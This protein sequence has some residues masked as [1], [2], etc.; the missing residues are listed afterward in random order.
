M[1]KEVLIELAGLKL[2]ARLNQSEVAE[3][4]W[5]ALPL[6]AQ[7]RLWGDELYF[8]VPLSLAAR[9]PQE[10]VEKGDLAYWAAGPALCI[11][12]GPTPASKGDECRPASPVEVIGRVLEE[13]SVLKKIKAGPVRLSKAGVVS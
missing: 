5:N 6:E 10:V 8:S 2:R 13:P 12:W 7:G 11:F 1:E 9:H 3:A 4:I